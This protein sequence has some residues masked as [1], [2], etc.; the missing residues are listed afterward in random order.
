MENEAFRI[1]NFTGPKENVSGLYNN[2]KTD[3]NSNCLIR[4]TT[5]S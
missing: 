4:L 5:A 2:M 3:Y 1:L